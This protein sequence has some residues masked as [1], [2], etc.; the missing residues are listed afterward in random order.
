MILE[1]KI[2]KILTLKTLERIQ[3]LPLKTLK[4]YLLK[5]F[6]GTNILSNLSKPNHIAQ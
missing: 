6:S 3:T 5:Q 4:Y 1:I 2:F